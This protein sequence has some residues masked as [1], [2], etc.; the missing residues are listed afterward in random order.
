ME[1]QGGVLRGTQAI[2]QLRAEG[3]NGV[4]IGLSGDFDMY[5]RHMD[6]GADRS[7]GKPLPSGSKM[8]EDLLALFS[9]RTY[10]IRES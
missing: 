1:G 6:A 2:A 4:L 10:D 8:R 9:S 7:R 5:Q 3:Y